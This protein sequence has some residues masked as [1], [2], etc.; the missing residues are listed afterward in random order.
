MHSLCMQ[1][2]LPATADNPAGPG[3]AQLY[4]YKQDRLEIPHA[5]SKFFNISTGTL[6]WEMTV[7]ISIYRGNTWQS[8][9]ALNK[10]DKSGDPEFFLLDRGGYLYQIEGVGSTQMSCSKNDCW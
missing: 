4:R 6:Q 5:F 3:S 7:E 10:M 8:N 2:L 9:L 1:L